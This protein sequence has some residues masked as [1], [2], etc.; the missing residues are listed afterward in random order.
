M[1]MIRGKDVD[2]ALNMLQFNKRRASFL[3]GNV[4][5]T[6]VANFNE[7]P[8]NAGTQGALFITEARADEGPTIKRFQPKDRGKAHPIMK[9][10]SHLVVSVEERA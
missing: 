9:R 4:L 1:D 7:N 6:A 3:V 10:T 8:E 2:D 5:K